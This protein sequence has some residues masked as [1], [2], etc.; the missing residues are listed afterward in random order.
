MLKGMNVKPING[1]T[2]GVIT[3][4]FFLDGGNNDNN[5]RWVATY[6]D[7]EQQNEKMITRIT[8]GHEEIGNVILM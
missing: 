7:A 6:Y 5:A 4:C 2:H 3:S 8:Y 1:T